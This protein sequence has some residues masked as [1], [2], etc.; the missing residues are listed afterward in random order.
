M[1]VKA[2]LSKTIGM[3]YA[4]RGVLLLSSTSFPSLLYGKFNNKRKKNRKQHQTCRV[5]FG[6]HPYNQYLKINNGSNHTSMS[7]EGF[8]VTELLPSFAISLSSMKCL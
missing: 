6:E 5:V 2:F 4:D 8:V 3:K 1:S 7:K